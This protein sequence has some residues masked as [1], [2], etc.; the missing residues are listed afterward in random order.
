MELRMRSSSLSFLAN[1]GIAGSIRSGRGGEGRIHSGPLLPAQV[2]RRPATAG[3]WRGTETIRAAS[4][5]QDGS[6][7]AE[8]PAPFGYAGP[9][10]RFAQDCKAA[11][12]RQR[13]SRNKWHDNLYRHSRQLVDRLMCSASDSGLLRTHYLEEMSVSS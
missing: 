3:P 2:I 6:R 7:V 11:S 1:S 4:S 8:E 13:R 5:S 10:R 9:R 12:L